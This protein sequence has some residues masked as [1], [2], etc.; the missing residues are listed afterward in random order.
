MPCTVPNVHLI[1]EATYKEMITITSEEIKVQDSSANKWQNLDLNPK[2]GDS[3]VYAHTFMPEN[4]AGETPGS[5]NPKK[6]QDRHIN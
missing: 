3:K 4:A 2:M 6:S 1:V 5:K